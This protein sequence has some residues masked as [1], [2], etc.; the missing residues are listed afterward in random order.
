MFTS[1]A[2]LDG[3]YRDLLSWIIR[4]CQCGLEKLQRPIW[5]TIKYIYLYININTI[6]VCSLINKSDCS[7]SGSSGLYN[8]ENM[9]DMKNN[10]SSKIEAIF[11]LLNNK[12]SINVTELEDSRGLQCSYH[13]L[14]AMILYSGLNWLGNTQ[15]LVHVHWY[16]NTPI[17]GKWLMLC[18]RLDG[19]TVRC[20][21]NI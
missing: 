2:F 19:Q 21:K 11:F 6:W 17:I 12:W 13:A 8:H 20:L 16:C 9:L 4:L 14:L 15:L 5:Q 7:M 10:V 18:K 1:T 3:G